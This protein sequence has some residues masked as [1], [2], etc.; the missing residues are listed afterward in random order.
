MKRL[1]ISQVKALHEDLIEQTGGSLGVRDDGLL[2][3]ALNSPFQ[4]FDGESLYPSIQQKASRLAYSLICDHPFIDGN[5][6]IGIH[7]MLVFL[8]LNGIVLDY[9]QEE[10]VSVGLGLASGRMGDKELLLWII[11]HQS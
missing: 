5:K 4:T 9:S 6:R 8:E 10:L 1:T 3:S 11:S 2:E 7:T